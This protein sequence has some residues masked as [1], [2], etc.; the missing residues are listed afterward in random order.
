MF[1]P[2]DPRVRVHLGVV[3][4]GDPPRLRDCLSTLVA[5]ES[6][7]EFAVSFLVNR[8]TMR[9]A[10]L[11]V[12][13]PD[14][15]LVERPLANLG[16]PG[17]LHLLRTLSDAELFVWVQDDMLPEP[18]WLDAL[19]DAADAHPSV[20]VFGALW[21][22]DQ[23]QVL[24][25]NGGWARPPDLV[26]G[27]NDTDTTVQDTPTEVTLLDWVTSKGC[28]TRT[29]VF[30]EVSGPV[31]RGPTSTTSRTGSCCHGTPTSCR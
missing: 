22:D 8:D 14:G 3:A 9:R 30:D 5:H 31:R 6:K 15:V 17:G 2:F 25:H 7:H 27:W 13:V 16:W 26:A 29:Q 21:V 11:C 1:V 24:E 4:L 18:G 20:G 23:G 28:L 12:E 19:V 10:P